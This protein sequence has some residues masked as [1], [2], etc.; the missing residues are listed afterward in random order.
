MDHPVQVIH[1]SPGPAADGRAPGR[2]LSPLVVGE[3]HGEGDVAAGEAEGHLAQPPE[4]VAVLG[5]AVPLRGVL[6][7]R[8]AQRLSL[9]LRENFHDSN[10]VFHV[11]IFRIPNEISNKGCSIKSIQAK[12]IH[13]LA[14]W[15]G[16]TWDSRRISLIQVN[17]TQMRD[18]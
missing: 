13:P 6:D 4:G 18:D 17:P 9:N 15:L 16:L 10:L 14:N 7:Q 3:L 2:D 12:T 5:A 1:L 11:N 8:L